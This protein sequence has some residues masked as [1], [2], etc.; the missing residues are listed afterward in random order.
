MEWLIGSHAD[1]LPLDLQFIK[2]IQD[3]LNTPVELLQK[4]GQTMAEMT[5][6]TIFGEDDR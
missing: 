2:F 3:K 6:S 1:S 4:L 5:S